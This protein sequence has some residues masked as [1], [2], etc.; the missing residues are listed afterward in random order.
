ML[1][2]MASSLHTTEIADKGWGL[3]LRLH[4]RGGGHSANF[5]FSF[6]FT[7]SSIHWLPIDQ[8][9]KCHNVLVPYPTIH[10]SEQKCVHFCS[11]WCIVGYGKDALWD[12]W[13]FLW[14][15]MIIFEVLPQSA[16]GTPV[17]YEHYCKIS[18]ISHTKSQHLNYS[19]L[20]LQLSLSN[21]LKPGVKSR[22]KM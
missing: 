15:V 11:E 4:F 19:H 5:L 14:N 9:H 6:F 16:A 12:W 21:P 13:D 22:M 1:P 8:S 7:E 17:K 3:P 2:F 10:Q 20:V 18:N